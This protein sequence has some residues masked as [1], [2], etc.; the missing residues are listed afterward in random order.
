MSRDGFEELVMPLIEYLNDNYHPHAQI[1]IG[2]NSAEIVEGIKCYS[3][4]QEKPAVR[5]IY[6][7]ENQ[8]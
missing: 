2:C 5:L 8:D 7:N 1:I 6:S 3:V 4:D